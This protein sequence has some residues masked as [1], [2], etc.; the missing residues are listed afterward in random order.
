MCQWENYDYTNVYISETWTD[1]NQFSR[2]EISGCILNSKKIITINVVDIFVHFWWKQ[3]F[4]YSFFYHHFRKNSK[5]WQNKLKIY[6]NVVTTHVT[7]VIE[8]IYNNKKK[9]R[10]HNNLLPTHTSKRG[11]KNQLHNRSMRE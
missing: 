2:I 11:E 1:Q 5:N 6:A 8:S 3:K 9:R 10:E 4:N 7:H